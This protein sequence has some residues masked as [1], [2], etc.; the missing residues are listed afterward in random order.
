MLDIV[1]RISHGAVRAAMAADRNSGYRPDPPGIPLYGIVPREL[2]FAGIADFAESS[3]RI[4]ELCRGEIGENSA[5]H[6]FR[7]PLSQG[8]RGC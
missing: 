1:Y 4:S 5:T 3:C 7:R 8:G 2:F 6:G